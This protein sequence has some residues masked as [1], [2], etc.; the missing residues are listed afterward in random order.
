M[1]ERHSGG[2]GSTDPLELEIY[3]AAVG[4]VLDEVETNLTRTAYSPLIYEYK[5]YTIGLLSP[6]FELINQSRYNLPLF[7]ADLGA[8]VRDCVEVLGRET[9]HRGDVFLTNFAAV[10]GQHLNNVVLAAPLFTGEDL[11]G[12]VAVRAHW[13]DVGGRTPGSMSWHARSIFEEGVQ[14]RALRVVRA[15]APQP[16]VV[17]TILANTRMIDYVRGDLMAQIGCCDLAQRRWDE[18]VACRWTQA[19]MHR[20]RAEQ[21]RRSAAYARQKVAQLPDGVFAASCLLDDSG[22]PGT[23]PLLMSLEVTVSGEQMT[24]D[25]ADMPPQVAAPINAGAT[26]GGVSLC[27]LAFKALVAPDYPLDEGL[28]DPL[29]INVVSGSMLGAG[30]TAPMG[31]WNNSLATVGDLVLKALAQVVPDRLPAGHHAT[32]GVYQFTGEGP[33][34]LWYTMDTIGGGWGGSAEHD[35]FSPLK[36]MFHGDNRELPMEVVESRFPLRYESAGFIPDSAGPGLHRGGLG[37]EKVVLT[38][39]DDVLFSSS[40]ERTRTPPWG[41]NGGLPG[42]SGGIDV[43]EPGEDTWTSALKVTDRRLPKG[44]RVRVRSHGGGGWGDPSLRSPAAR[45]ADAAAGLVTFDR[46]PH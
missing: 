39:A 36:T 44:S 15:G 30:Q 10:Q 34:G 13:A 33:D 22:S 26:G 8:P 2:D 43:Q 12:Y 25:L 3:R 19:D 23:A 20:L 11:V 9:L 6:E 41:I 24:I 35:G 27:R 42:R 5:D 37:V 17:A 32:M 4:S 18:R 16:E 46:S 1:T 14:Y 7:M 29:A 31:H 40:M 28:F 38:E 21:R 45:D